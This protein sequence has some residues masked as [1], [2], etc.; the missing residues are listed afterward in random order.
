MA[1]PPSKSASSNLYVESTEMDFHLLGPAA[2]PLRYP[3]Q[4]LALQVRG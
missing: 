4:H 2:D 1:V 3:D